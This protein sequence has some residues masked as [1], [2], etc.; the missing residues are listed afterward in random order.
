MPCFIVVL[1]LL[2]NIQVYIVLVGN[3]LQGKRK[4]LWVSLRPFVLTPFDFCLGKDRSRSNVD[5]SNE[6]GVFILKV[7]L[8]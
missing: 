2:F 5:R 6:K 4:I 8:V 1:N 7:L 3:Y